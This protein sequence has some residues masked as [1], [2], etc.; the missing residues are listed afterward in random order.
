M[1][2]QVYSACYFVDSEHVE[3][4]VITC[5]STH[6]CLRPSRVSRLHTLTR[7]ESMTEP[8][9]TSRSLRLFSQAGRLRSKLDSV[10]LAGL[11]WLM[12]KRLCAHQLTAVLE[13]GWWALGEGGNGC[14]WT[15]T[16]KLF[17]LPTALL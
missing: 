2:R 16:G 1:L 11:G 14:P 12:G 13:Q 10:V 4:L 9:A 7:S 5:G 15:L 3:D 6:V 8:G 17:I